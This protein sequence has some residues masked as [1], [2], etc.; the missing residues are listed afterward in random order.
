MIDKPD[1]LDPRRLGRGQPASRVSWGR[2][3]SRVSGALEPS[4]Y[5]SYRADTNRTSSCVCS[6]SSVVASVAVAATTSS[7]CLSRK[8]S[9]GF[10]TRPPEGERTAQH[11][12]EVLGRLAEHVVVRVN[13]LPHSSQ[14]MCLHPPQCR[15]RGSAGCPR[16]TGVA[17]RIDQIVA[18]RRR[19]T[20]AVCNH[21]G[22][23]V[24]VWCLSDVPCTGETIAECDLPLVG[25]TV[26]WLSSFQASPPGLVSRAVTD[27]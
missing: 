1:I 10:L 7:R 17:I 12:G 11:K 5:R 3:H 4:R 8:V 9:Q 15:G 16:D 24:P 26:W 21:D 27:R 14:Q 19:C 6:L 18:A 20:V 2:E 13:A 25:D 22:D 23:Q